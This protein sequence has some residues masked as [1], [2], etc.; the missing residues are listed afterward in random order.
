ML[1]I[2]EIKLMIEKLRRLKNEDFQTIIDS[3]LKILEDLAEVVDANNQQ[4]IDRLDK[5]PGWFT[6][7]LDKKREKTNVDDL[8]FRM[9]QT[10]IFQFSKTNLYNCIEIGPGNGMFSKEL[11]SWRKIFFLDIHNLE[12]KIRRRFHPGHQSIYYFSLPI[13]IHAITYQKILV[14]LF[15]VG[16]LLSFSRKNMLKNI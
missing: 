6:K 13:I 11:R 8:L 3:N 4:M 12:E 7:D 16:T 10:K 2:E 9:I 14:I 15:L 1:S 5:T